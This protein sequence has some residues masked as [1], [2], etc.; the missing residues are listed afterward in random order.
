M[1]LFKFLRRFCE[2]NQEEENEMGREFGVY[3]GED[4][5]IEDLDGET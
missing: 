5:C 1:P 2:G 4:K 3:G